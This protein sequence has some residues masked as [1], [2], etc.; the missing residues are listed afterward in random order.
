MRYRAFGQL[1]PAILYGYLGYL[2]VRNLRTSIRSSRGHDVAYIIGHPVRLGL[3]LL[4]CV[5]PVALFLTRPPPT[6]RDGALAARAAAFGGT[7]ILVGAGAVRGHAGEVIASL[8]AWFTDGAAVLFAGFTALEVYSLLRLRSSFSIIPEARRLV[9]SG[10]Y[11]VVRNPL[12][13]AEIA[14]A[15]TWVASEPRLLLLIAMVPFIALQ[16]LRIRFEERL[17]R[18]AF[19]EYAAYFARTRRLIPFV[20]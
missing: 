8:P 9:T 10:P 7:L 19:S 4:F 2:V 20:W 11:A 17:L 5:I 18:R 3:Y 16:L 6:A 15:V 13:A 14:A 12:Y 1:V